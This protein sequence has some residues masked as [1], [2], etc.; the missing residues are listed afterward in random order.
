MS[1]PMQ[2]IEDIARLKANTFNS[3]TNTK[4][5]DNEVRFTFHNHEH[6]LKAFRNGRAKDLSEAPK[7]KGK[8]ILILGSGPTLD[9]AWPL[10]QKWKGDIMVSSSQAT[11]AVYYGKEPDYIVSLD[12]DTPPSEF[13][14]DTWKGR[15]SAMIIHPGVM[16]DTF[17]FWKGPL[18]M[19]RKLQPQTPFYA[20]AQRV[21]YSTLGNIEKGRYNPE[22]AKALITTEIPMLAC[23][24]AAQIC[25]AKLMGYGQ[26]FLVG[27][28][29][30]FP[31]NKDRFIRWDYI[32]GEW[33][34]TDAGTPDYAH[35]EDLYHSPAV[36]IGGINTTVMMAFYAHQIITSW[37]ITEADI[38][39]TSNLG[40]MRSFRYCPL[41][42]VVSRQG[43]DI[44]SYSLK[45]RILV[46]EEYC[47]RQNIYF[48]R[49]G[50]QGIMPHEF[51]DPITEIPKMLTKLK[52][53]LT[54]NGR[55][56]DLDIAKNMKRFNR[57]FKMVAKHAAQKPI[58]LK[59]TVPEEAPI[60]PC[61]KAGS[62]ETITEQE[63]K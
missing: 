33:K 25:V 47:A 56:D 60:Y 5:Y 52:H 8:P 54:A 23:V 4:H 62:C 2:K 10:I 22:K 53:A 20:G 55:G 42:K 36:A 31:G 29:L 21:G 27:A 44:K 16:P 38:V 1:E 37:R 28:D 12:P 18:Y 24:L 48:V 45:K 26:M 32:D 39:N 50:K 40:L 57:L 14:A 51:Q 61:N 43:R 63:K 59:K 15:K 49:V 30:S 17:D 13:R 7:A 6:I 46:S 19:F 3:A 11:T 9:A 58:L 34:S 41:E 35:L